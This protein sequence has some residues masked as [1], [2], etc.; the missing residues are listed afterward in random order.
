MPSLYPEEAFLEEDTDPKSGKTR[1]SI[2]PELIAGVW[3]AN[4]QTFTPNEK[5]YKNLDKKE[6]D[7]FFEKV[8]KNY[9]RKLKERISNQ[10]IDVLRFNIEDYLNGFK[11]PDGLQLPLTQEDIVELIRYQKTIND[12][13]SNFQEDEE[14]DNSS[15]IF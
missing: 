13:E 4:T 1:Y 2:M 3:D 11:D 5:Y 15:E 14:D 7:E 9:V 6:R 8:H 10:H 12:Q